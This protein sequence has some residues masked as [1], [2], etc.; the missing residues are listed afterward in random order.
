MIP[1]PD[2]A[3]TSSTGGQ[4]NADRGSSD[5]TVGALRQRRRAALRRQRGQ[6]KYARSLSCALWLLS[7]PDGASSS[8]VGGQLKSDRGCLRRIGSRAF[9]QLFHFL[10]GFA[11]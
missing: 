8:S 7:M 9:V 2:D 5:A 10:H 6:L 1:T 3:A 11:D 4:L